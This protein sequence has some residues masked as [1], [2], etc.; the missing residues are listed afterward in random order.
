MKKVYEHPYTLEQIKQHYG[1]EVFQ[2][3]AKCPVHRW[4]AITG[5][6]LIH[7]EPSR[8]ELERIWQNWQ[9]MDPIDKEISDEKSLELFGMTN[10]EHY[11]KLSDFTLDES[12]TIP[13]NKDDEIEKKLYKKL[14]PSYTHAD[15][16]V[17]WYRNEK[18]HLKDDPAADNKLEEMFTTNFSNLKDLLST[19]DSYIVKLKKMKMVGKKLHVPTTT[20]PIEVDP[21]EDFDKIRRLAGAKQVVKMLGDLVNSDT[22]VEASEEKYQIEDKDRKNIRLWRFT[23]KVMLWRTETYE[24]TNKFIFQLWQNSETLG[25]GDAYGDPDEQSPYCTH[26]INHWE[27][28]AEGFDPYYQYWFLKIDDSSLQ[29]E[30]GDLSNPN[31]VAA[32]KSLEGKGPSV[33]IAMNDSNNDLLD[34]DDSSAS[35]DELPFSNECESLNNSILAFENKR[36]NDKCEKLSKDAEWLKSNLF[37]DSK[38]SYRNAKWFKDVSVNG[39]F[40]VDFKLHYE[41]IEDDCYFYDNREGISFE[42]VVKIL[43]CDPEIFEYPEFYSW[44][45]GDAAIGNSEA[46]T[47]KLSPFELTYTDLVKIFQYEGQYLVDEGKVSKS[48]LKDISQLLDKDFDGEGNSLA[49]SFGECMRLGTETKVLDEVKSQ[50]VEKAKFIT[51]GND[52]FDGEYFKCHMDHN[53]VLKCVKTYHLDMPSF[54]AAWVCTEENPDDDWEDCIE[55]IFIEEPSGVFDLDYKTWNQICKK[56]ADK[57]IGILTKKRDSEG[58]TKFDFDKDY[59]DNEE[60]LPRQKSI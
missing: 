18:K 53:D 47:A 57:I 50:L 11:A 48:Q 29:L 6:E 23:S 56:A 42:N 26:S 15:R 17:R 32:F 49:E 19:Y 14:P 39:D 60:N 59:L 55:G 25:R 28:Y 10:A 13:L 43:N 33:L 5:I 20:K 44:Y 2:S 45:S 24:S 1:D 16:V 36:F 12:L 54:L 22:A 31:V 35:I 46:M 27:D 30:E 52:W 3:L 8:E 34:R 7:K 38:R 51:S 4:R 41:A 9:L 40:S 58:Q 21:I 37:S